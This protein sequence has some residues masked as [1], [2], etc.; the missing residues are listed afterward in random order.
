MNEITIVNQNEAVATNPSRRGFCASALAALGVSLADVMSPEQLEA[1]DTS[2]CAPTPQFQP[3]VPVAELVRHQFRCQHD[4]QSG[5]AERHHDRG[6]GAPVQAHE[7]A[8]L[9][10]APREQ[11]RFEMGS[12]SRALEMARESRPAGTGTHFAR[13]RRRP[14]SDSPVE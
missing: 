9:R 2:V 5:V 1:Q 11:F 7:A 13:A 10:R 14:C 3:F 4:S 6:S 8:L 12:E